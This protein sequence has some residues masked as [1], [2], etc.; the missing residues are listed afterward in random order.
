[1]ER[2]ELDA[3]PLKYDEEESRDEPVE[4]RR[5]DGVTYATRSASVPHADGHSV[6]KSLHR[7]QLL[8]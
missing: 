5:G 1:M 3:H 2:A 4:F 7:R 6:R 8:F